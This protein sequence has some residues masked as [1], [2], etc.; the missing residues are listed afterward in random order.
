MDNDK[1]PKNKDIPDD[2][3]TLNDSDIVDNNDSTD[4]NESVDDYTNDDD[5]VDNDSV[6]E[7]DL[8]QELAQLEDDIQ[9]LEEKSLVADRRLTKI[10]KRT[11]ELQKFL[12]LVE[13]KEF[14]K[15]HS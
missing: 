13:I 10:K 12:L 1:K 6:E 7:D 14:I 2:G 15:E 9:E 11:C 8:D 5:W 3:N 4:N